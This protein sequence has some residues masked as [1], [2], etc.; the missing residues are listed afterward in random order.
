[1][2]CEMENLPLIRKSL[3]ANFA[4]R[5]GTRLSRDMIEIKSPANGIAPGDLHRVLGRVL[6]HDLEEDRPITWDSLI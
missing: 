5:R 2:P 4:L 1:M 6:A 3:V